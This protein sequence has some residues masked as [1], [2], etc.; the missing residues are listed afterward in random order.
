V[1]ANANIRKV[2]LC[3]PKHRC[4]KLSVGLV[5]HTQIHFVCTTQGTSQQ[6]VLMGAQSESVCAYDRNLTTVVFCFTDVDF[7]DDGGV[8]HSNMLEYSFTVH[9]IILLNVVQFL[10]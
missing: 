7:P 4:C 10:R 1:A 2:Q 6:A 3:E 8:C 5:M 9:R